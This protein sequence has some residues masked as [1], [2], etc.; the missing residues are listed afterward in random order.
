MNPTRAANRNKPQR[1]IWSRL[2]APLVSF[3]IG[4]ILLGP[5]A[6]TQSV[7]APAPHRH[8]VTISAPGTR[9]SEPSIAVNP[10]N[11]N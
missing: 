9:G 3:I 1:A 11:A 6:F 4:V 5:A 8:S 10:T 7:L 2:N